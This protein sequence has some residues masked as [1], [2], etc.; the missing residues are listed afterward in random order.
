MGPAEGSRSSRDSTAPAAPK[1]LNPIG[2]IVQLC[3]QRILR[4]GHTIA[5]RRAVETYVQLYLAGCLMVPFASIKPLQRETF[6]SYAAGATLGWFTLVLPLAYCLQ[7]RTLPRVSTMGVTGILLAVA[8]VLI[9]MKVASEPGAVRP[10]ILSYVLMS[11]QLMIGLPDIWQFKIL[12]VMMAWLLVNGIEMAFRL[13]VYD[14][15]GWTKNSEDLLHTY[16]GCANPP[17]A[18]GFSSGLINFA[19]HSLY[20]YFGYRISMSF[21]RGQQRER[22]RI[23]AAIHTI[24]LVTQALAVF[25]LE[26]AAAVLAGEESDGV[27]RA[28][29]NSLHSLLRNLTSYRPY[30]PHSVFAQDESDDD[31]DASTGMTMPQGTQ[32]TSL[33][34]ADEEGAVTPAKDG[35]VQGI[36]CP[37]PGTEVD[38]GRTWAKRTFGS[39]GKG[40]VPNLT[41]PGSEERSRSMGE[42]AFSSDSCGSSSSPTTKSPSAFSGRKPSATGI[43]S[44]P[45]LPCPGLQVHHAATVRRVSLLVCNR[46]GF[47]SHVKQATTEDMQQ[48]MAI[49]VQ[50]FVDCV[51]DHK[52]IFD[53]LAADHFFASFGAVRSLGAHSAAAV[54]CAAHIQ[55]ARAREPSAASVHGLLDLS[56]HCAVCAGQAMCGDFGSFTVQRFMVIGG[57]PSQLSAVERLASRWGLS[58][59][60]NRMAKEDTQLFW[61]Y[62]VRKLFVMPKGGARKPT[63]LWELVEPKSDSGNAEWMYQLQGQADPWEG[64]NAA[65]ELFAAGEEAKALGVLAKA[66]D[67]AQSAVVRDAL[68]ALRECHEKCGQGADNPLCICV[69]GDVASNA[70]TIIPVASGRA[71]FL[72][73]SM[74]DDALTIMSPAPSLLPAAGRHL[75]R[76]FRS[77]SFQNVAGLPLTKQSPSMAFRRVSEQS[78]ASP[79]VPSARSTQML[80]PGVQRRRKQSRVR[81]QIEMVDIDD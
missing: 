25:D 27:P 69:L 17:C 16:Y 14:I 33:S 47:L 4:P 56:R 21:A 28:L 51:S 75:Q 34:E 8:I 45:L 2:C 79:L 46:G 41:V 65:A 63:Q 58:I 50:Y 11:S 67:S 12:G 60:A 42:S 7:A 31:G 20:L 37:T 3:V 74:S 78:P 76:S 9:D 57:L 39:L 71:L 35:D 32:G 19:V 23:I 22:D 18:T 40:H 30:L 68:A 15:E 36:G 5:E 59:V 55:E 70:G 29:R 13:G 66:A 43:I 77:A 24:E 1:A 81:L 64:Y 26:D 38:T 54:Q 61:N 52:G 53:L 72:T 10:W 62:R 48:W 80:L 49:E 44:P 73:P 6:D